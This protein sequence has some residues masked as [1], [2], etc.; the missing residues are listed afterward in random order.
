MQ[1]A[2][3]ALL[4]A[5]KL[6]SECH[7]VVA[8]EGD[9]KAGVIRVAERHPLHFERDRVFVDVCC[10]KHQGELIYEPLRESFSRFSGTGYLHST[11]LSAVSE[12]THER[13]RLGA[14]VAHRDVQGSRLVLVYPQG[15]CARRGRQ[16]YSLALDTSE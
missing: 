14:T 12:R 11:I 8:V 6:Q 4:A 10:S 9:V 16:V 5:I 13:A 15:G 3:V 2:G 7:V 1:R